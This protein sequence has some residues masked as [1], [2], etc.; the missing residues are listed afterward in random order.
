MLQ[1]ATQDMDNPLFRHHATGGAGSRGTMYKRDWDSLNCVGGDVATQ[2]SM[3]QR[4]AVCTTAHDSDS[5]FQLHRENC[6]WTPG[7][8]RSKYLTATTRLTRLFSERLK[9]PTKCMGFVA[10][11]PA[12]LHKQIW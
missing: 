11:S 3:E 5:G 1:P 12:W 4:F 8:A 6:S 9:R 7:A 10:G 2:S